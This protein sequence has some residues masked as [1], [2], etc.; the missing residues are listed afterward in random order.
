MWKASIGLLGILILTTVDAQD[1]PAPAPPPPI[2]IE[3]ENSDYDLR[4][5]VSHFIDNVVI[6]RGN[7][8]VHAD[9]GTLY[10]TEGRISRVELRG[11]P[12]TWRDVL[13]DGTEL[14]GEATNI[15]FDVATNIVTLSGNAWIRH[16]QG[17]FTGDELVYDLNNESLFGRSAGDNRVRVIIESGALPQRREQE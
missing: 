16:A 2:E 13:E 9:I 8:I 4:T 7:M 15:H 1:A 11:T 14:T 12:S 6:T 5:G 3:A 10:Q 17:E